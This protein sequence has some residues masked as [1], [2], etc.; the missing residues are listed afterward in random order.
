AGGVVTGSERG[1][2]STRATAVSRSSGAKRATSAAVG[3]KPV[4]ASRWRAPSSPIGG[5]AWASVAAASNETASVGERR[6]VTRF[7]TGRGRRLL[8]DGA[9]IAVVQGL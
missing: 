8:T 6:V 4:R 2:A 3:P 5:P 9:T 7:T 1:D